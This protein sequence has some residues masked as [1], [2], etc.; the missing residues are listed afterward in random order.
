[1]TSSGSVD[2]ADEALVDVTLYLGL[3]R[4]YRDLLPAPP[5]SRRNPLVRRGASE[6]DRRGHA[7]E[8]LRGLRFLTTLAAGA[9]LVTDTIDDPFPSRLGIASWLGDVS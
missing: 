8:Q 6:R 3:P 9:V 1:M 7:E 2:A 5:R 4:W